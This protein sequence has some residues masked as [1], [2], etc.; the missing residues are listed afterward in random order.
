MRLLPPSADLNGTARHR[1]P[2]HRGKHLLHRQ[3]NCFIRIKLVGIYRHP[4]VD[5]IGVDDSNGRLTGV[6]T[7][8]GHSNLV[9][10]CA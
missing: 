3:P 6:G 8:M 5:F 10:C 7:W 4:L 2:A 1:V 9:T